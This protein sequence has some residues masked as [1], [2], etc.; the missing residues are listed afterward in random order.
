M[1]VAPPRREKQDDQDQGEG[2]VHRALGLGRK[3]PEAG[4]VEVKTG[5]EHGQA[6]HQPALPADQGPEARL[7]VVLAQDLLQVQGAVFSRGGWREVWHV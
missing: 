1:A 2:Q 5:H 4:S 7:G 3:Q 6:A